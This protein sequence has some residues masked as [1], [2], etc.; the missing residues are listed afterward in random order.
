MTKD[1]TRFTY[2]MTFIA[3]ILIVEFKKGE[4]PIMR[5][6][7]VA[8]C[9][10]GMVLAKPAL[11][12][13][14][15]VV[16]GKHAELTGRVIQLLKKLGIDMIYVRDQATDDIEI[17]QVISDQTR[18]E[19]IS[20]IYSTFNEM[21]NQRR[22][23]SV[24]GKAS[25]SLYDRFSTICQRLIDEMKSS[26]STINLLGNVYVHE[27]YVYSHSL[28]TTIYALGIAMKKGYSDKELM[29]IGVGALLHDIGQ[30]KI[31]DRIMQKESCLT[32]EEYEMVKKH[33]EYGFDLLRQEYGFPLLA[34][35]C[36]YQH[37]ERLDGS[38]YPRGLKKDEIH[39]HA[40]LLAVADVFEALTSHRAHRRAM[41]PHM[42]MEILYGQSGTQFDQE[43]VELFR[44]TVAIYPIG[45]SVKLNT[46]ETAIVVGYNEH[47]LTRP[48]V[49]VI[50][51]SAG[52]P[53][54][55]YTEIDLSKNLSLTIEECD[56]MI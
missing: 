51:D 35:H 19:T 7:S 25:A 9:E 24:R 29:E 18:C 6:I 22:S 28:N 36:A 5:L 30:M 17:D 10:P 12:Q 31:P 37:H 43:Y 4:D 15:A 49:R 27:N 55:R 46:G 34:A 16:L 38:G 1:M 47:M 11:N 40:R 13:Q 50:K 33:T 32:N 39:R 14:G 52:A 48:I 8:R 2:H 54:P 56:I 45:V 21:Q 53:L 41:L 3:N 26:N 23:S 44:K 42:A 20:A